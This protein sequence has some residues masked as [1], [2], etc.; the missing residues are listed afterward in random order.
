MTTTKP[1]R[2]RRAVPSNGRE[3][4]AASRVARKAAAETKA[5]TILERIPVEPGTG[6]APATGKLGRLVELMRRPEGASLHQLCEETNWQAH[7]V[8][9]ALAGSLKRS[10]GY[11]IASERID[12]V[13]IYRIP[14]TEGQGAAAREIPA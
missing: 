9:G 4:R 2:T 5:P 10:R 1:T 11:Q 3:T 8:R 12:G 7:S 13:R 6:P 14:A